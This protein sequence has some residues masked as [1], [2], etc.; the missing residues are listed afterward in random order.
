MNAAQFIEQANH[1]ADISRAIIREEIYRPREVEVK[2]DA[3]PVTPV[4]Q[5]VERA[6]RA[7]IEKGFPGHGIVGEEYGDINQDADYVWVLDPI[8]GTMAFVAGL[9]TFATLIALTW[10]GT[11]ILGVMDSPITGERWIG[12]DGVGTTLNGQAIQPRPCKTLG[13]AF[14][15]TSSPLYFT[16][17]ADLE[18]YNQI[19]NAVQFLI[20]GGGCHAFGRVAHGYID[21]A[22]ETA[23][24]I[25]DYLAL[26][27]I[28]TNAG[29]FIYDWEGNPLTLSSGPKFVASGD[30]EVHSL[31]LNILGN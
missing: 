18:A 9:P 17:E 8:D 29:G 22:F 7:V 20:F 24:D 26:V 23:H 12:I 2:S 31:A 1:F 19:K 10:H 15:Q 25:H 6:L 4:D 28:I 30:Q 14:A 5:K 13:Q 11:P 3:T 21:L 16:S 27:P